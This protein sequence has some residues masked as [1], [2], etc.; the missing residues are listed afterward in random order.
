[1]NRYNPT[2]RGN[3]D[4]GGCKCGWDRRAK[5]WV[6]NGCKCPHLDR[7]AREA[8]EAMQAEKRAV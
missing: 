4:T 7:A 2:R 6:R 1:M 5:K 8:S 3:I